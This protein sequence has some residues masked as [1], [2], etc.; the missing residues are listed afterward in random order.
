MKKTD[1]LEAL[2]EVSEKY[3]SEARER[4]E[5]QGSFTENENIVMGVEVMNKTNIWRKIAPAVS[6]ASAFALVVGAVVYMSRG[7]HDFNNEGSEGDKPSATENIG[8]SDNSKVEFYRTP[9]LSIDEQNC[10]ET[11]L[12]KNYENLTFAE[13]FIVEFPEIDSFETFTMTVKPNIS[14]KMAYELF[15][16]AVEKYFPDVYSEE[17]KKLLYKGTGENASGEII[18]GTIEEFSEEFLSDGAKAPFMFMTDH[19][20]MLQ[21]FSNGGIQTMTGTSAFNL[22]Y[23][24]NDGTSSVGMYCASDNNRVVERIHIPL[25]GFESDMEYSLLDAS[26]KLTSA[27]AYTEDILINDFNKEVTNPELIPEVYDAWVVDMGDGIYGYHFT[28]TNTYK[29]IR[30]DAQPMLRAGSSSPVKDEDCKEYDNFP[31]YAFTIENEKLD[32][33][34][35]V[36]YNLAYD[37]N[38]VQTH[39]SIIT[40]EQATDILSESVSASAGLVIDR[41]E[42]MYTPYYEK[43]KIGQSPLTADVAWR[44]AGSN[45]N[46]G[47]SYLFYVNALTGEFDYYKYS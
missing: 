21:M 32:S 2:G 43:G 34:M 45:T 11:I 31:G 30:F 44:F 26:V 16:E 33:V 5:K 8:N 19:R 29:G 4:A 42:F 7:R 18:S 36:G 28:I 1:L 40:A 22:D 15:D 24:D 47:Y 38:D 41:A 17:D 37:I 3:L 13:D 10:A 27:I 14:G 20:G 9:L 12:N 25:S 46:D 39:D 23:P 35:S 6:V